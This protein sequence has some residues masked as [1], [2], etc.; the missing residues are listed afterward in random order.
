MRSFEYNLS[1]TD[2]HHR[3]CAIIFLMIFMCSDMVQ[4]GSVFMYL[5]VAAR[6]YCW[7]YFFDGQIVL[8]K[9]SNYYSLRIHY[10]LTARFNTISIIIYKNGE[11]NIRIYF[12]I[13]ILDNIIR[14]SHHSTQGNGERKLVMWHVKDV[15]W[16]LVYWLDLADIL[17]LINEYLCLLTWPTL[18]SHSN[19]DKIYL[20]TVIEIY[21]FTIDNF[22]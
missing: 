8:K 16:Y 22:W 3:H 2:V 17:H 1:H 7:Q 19:H 9:Y 10:I 15:Y 20:N 6:R 18:Q 14:D 4:S 21:Y 13:K 12:L 11:R 5:P